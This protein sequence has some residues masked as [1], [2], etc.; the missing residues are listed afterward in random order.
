MKMHK[1]PFL[2]KR[3]EYL[4]QHFAPKKIANI[5]RDINILETAR[6]E[7]FSLVEAEPGLERYPLLKETL[8]RKWMG[9]LELIKS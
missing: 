7:A 6:K 1:V 9:R 5:V 2:Y 3:L 4:F 8:Q